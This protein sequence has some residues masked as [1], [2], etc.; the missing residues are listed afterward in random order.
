MTTLEVASAESVRRR[1]ARWVVPFFAGAAVLLVPWIVLLATRLPAAHA[2]RHWDVTWAGFDVI[3]SLLLSAVAVAAWRRS[4]WL[5]GVATAAAVLLV[6]DA[7]FDI[8]TSSSTVELVSSV[9]MALL[10]E[11]PV[12]VVCLLIARDA[13]RLLARRVKQ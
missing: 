11:L 6:V 10:V 2:T 3:L 13:E 1:P 5:E 7:W 9:A 12:A 8:T 4:P